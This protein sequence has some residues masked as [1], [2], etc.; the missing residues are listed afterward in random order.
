MKTNKK[1]LHISVDDVEI[2]IK[3]IKNNN[4]KSIYDEPFF[5]QLKELKKN[6]TISLYCYSEIFKD[7]PTKYRNELKDTAHW[8]KFGLHSFSSNKDY[9]NYNYQEAKNEYEKFCEEVI[10]FTGNIASIDRCPR[11]HCF[12]ASK[13]AI[14]GMRDAKYGILGLLTSEIRNP[15]WLLNNRINYNLERNK[16][17]KNVFYDKNINIY[18][19]RT[20]IRCDW[21]VEWKN[22]IRVYPLSFGKLENILKD[23][24]KENKILEIF[25]H[26]WNGKA[27]YLLKEYIKKTKINEIE[28]S[29]FQDEI[30][31]MRKG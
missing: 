26:E 15:N 22:W 10:K 6:I 28:F 16:I 21:L 3:N 9:S 24:M 18:Y 23:K 5:K 11:L 25:F 29:F 14:L 12:R 27:F 13:E 17:K 8:L 4:Y 1:K 20:D 30:E 2:C 19:I 31:K 7:M